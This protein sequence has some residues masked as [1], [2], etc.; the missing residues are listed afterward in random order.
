MLTFEEEIEAFMAADESDA[1]EES[2]SEADTDGYQPAEERR[3]HLEALVKRGGVLGQIA[4]DL[5]DAMN[6]RE[7]AAE[8]A[9][10]AAAAAAALE[11]GDVDFDDRDVQASPLAHLAQKRVS[12]D[13]AYLALRRE[14]LTAEFGKDNIANLMQV[15]EAALAAVRDVHLAPA[16][17][18]VPE[19]QAFQR[20]K[21][22]RARAAATVAD[23]RLQGRTMADDLADAHADIED[24]VAAIE[25]GVS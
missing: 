21:V 1:G 24:T 4:G 25:A 12:D 18:E 7:A 16:L 17:H 22:E 3:S 10:L 19:Y 5:I 14:Q 11:A 15:E 20:Q 8:Q 6:A 9:R 2:E 13:T 23:M